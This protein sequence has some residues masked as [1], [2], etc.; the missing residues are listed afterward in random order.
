MDPGIGG[1]SCRL[2]ER[3]ARRRQ[4]RDY[5]RTDPLNLNCVTWPKV[6]A[7]IF[8]GWHADCIGATCDRRS[9]KCSAVDDT[10]IVGGEAIVAP[11]LVHEINRAG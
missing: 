1:E 2:R 4:T 11:S 5:T 9:E 8:S 6:G 3:D 10:R 7:R